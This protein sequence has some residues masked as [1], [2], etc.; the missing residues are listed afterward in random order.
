MKNNQNDPKEIM[1]LYVGENRCLCV[2]VYAHLRR[3]SRACVNF[4][5]RKGT[6][7]GEAIGLKWYRWYNTKK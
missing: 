7:D 5:R 1:L 6:V 2:K 3:G 4:N